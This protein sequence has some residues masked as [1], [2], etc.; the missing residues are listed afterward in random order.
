MEIREELGVEKTYV[1]VKEGAERIRK[2]LDEL[3][4]CETELRY[5][6]KLIF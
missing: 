5:V 3:S 4:D 2:I 1:L 6:S